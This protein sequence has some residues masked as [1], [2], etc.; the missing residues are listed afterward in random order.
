MTES[1]N[2]KWP[3]WLVLLLLLAGLVRMTEAQQPAK[4]PKIGYLSARSSSPAGAS[5][6]F[7][8]EIRALGYV[9]GKSIALESRH[10]DNKLDRLRA[11]ADELVG[12]KVDVLLTPAYLRF[13]PRD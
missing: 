13:S 9:E 11:L 12:L 2:L 3:G 8:R 4:I 1:D 7:L 5:D 6:L 10:A